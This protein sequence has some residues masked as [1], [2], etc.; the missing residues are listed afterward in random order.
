MSINFESAMSRCEAARENEPDKPGRKYNSFEAC[1]L[2]YCGPDKVS[3]EH[4]DSNICPC[5][6]WQDE[7]KDDYSAD[8][9][10]QKEGE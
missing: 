2:D 5:E 9:Y 8:D 4:C 3:C 1:A 10:A 6:D 7:T